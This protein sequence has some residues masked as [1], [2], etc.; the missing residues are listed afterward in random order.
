MVVLKAEEKP[1]MTIQSGLVSLVGILKCDIDEVFDVGHDYPAKA[2]HDIRLYV[3][4][5]SDLSLWS[6]WGHQ[7]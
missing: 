4:R 2:L 3:Y 6:T 5:H 1:P 7:Q